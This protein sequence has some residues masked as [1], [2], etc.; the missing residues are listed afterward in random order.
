MPSETFVGV[1]LSL[2]C[3]YGTATISAVALIVAAYDSLVL[4]VMSRY[5]N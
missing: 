3:E 1:I 5:H 2:A 4:L